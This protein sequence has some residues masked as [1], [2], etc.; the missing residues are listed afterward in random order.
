MKKISHKIMLSIIACCLVTSTVIAL[1]TNSIY[2]SMLEK[3]AEDILLQLSQLES[4]NINAILNKTTNY[5]DSIYSFISSTL[6]LS[7]I[8]SDEAY[9][10]SYINMINPFIESLANQYNESIGIA[11]II[12]PEITNKYY[13]LIYERTAPGENVQ[14][15]SKFTKED[16]VKGSEKMAW[17]YNVLDNK[18]GVWSEPHTDEFS[19]SWRFAFTKPLYV[20]N[21]LIGVIAIDLFFDSFK[22]DILNLKVYDNGYAFLLNEN[23]DFIVHNDYSVD[24]NFDEIYSSDISFDED[25]GVG[26]YLN[27]GK[28][29]LI[30]YSKLNNNTIFAITVY[31]SDIFS[32]VFKSMFFIIV[33]TIILVI[34]TSILAIFLS[35]KISKP[36]MLL[37]ELINVTADLDLSETDK[38]DSVLNLKDEIKLMADS[39]INLRKSLRENMNTIKEY[40]IE[41]SSHADSLNIITTEL[42]N[43]SNNISLSVNELSLGSQEQAEDAQAGSDML[44]SLDS[45]VDNIIN[46]T[47]IL[48]NNYESAKTANENGISSI[49]SLED[50]LNSS[51]E[52][53]SK[54]VSNVEKLSDQSQLIGNILTVITSISEQTNLLSLNAAIEAARAGEA[55][56]GF[57]VVAKEIRQ[58]SEQTSKA[59]KE[60]AGIITEIRSEIDTTK[61]NIIDS[62]N[63]I[64]AANESMSASKDAFDSITTSFDTMNIQINELISNMDDIK[65]FKENVINSIQGITAICEESAAS[66]EEISASIEE[67]TESVN[68]IADASKELDL[69]VNKLDELISQFKL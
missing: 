68:T 38:Y 26:T 27:N 67:Q 17:Y 42:K 14:K 53:G 63:A 24:S 36:I 5:M 4:N 31:E 6:D 46:I 25:H 9:A 45:K 41:T 58:L 16:F 3:N 12:N 44:S 2:Y 64:I 23:L 47:S 8:S 56:K 61:N 35:N 52:I 69:I 7:K 10:D 40:S 22:E 57:G 1:I 18:E 37:T 32:T 20:N 50:K 28:K 13:E 33:C 65:E 11:F 51:S 66:T 39:V 49:S 29:S 48:S 54:T 34:L 19:D 21:T 55:G 15:L 43:T 60:I 30:C 62:N 59:T